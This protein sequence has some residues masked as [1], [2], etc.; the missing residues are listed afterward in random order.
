MRSVLDRVRH[1]VLFELIGVAIVSP[2]AGWLFH[3]PMHRVGALAVAI[4]LFAT[5]W[6][7]VYNLAF[8]HALRRIT[9]RV[10]KTSWER[11]LHAIV[12]EA[13]MLVFTLAP[14]MWWMGFGLG[15]AL[16]MN[17]ALMVFYLVYTYAYNL[18]YDII[19]PIPAQQPRG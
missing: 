17:V 14:V 9:G 10:Y 7:Y 13:G 4:S 6:N 3:A 11:I 19:F 18:A 1:A 8:D 5:V 16:T 2:L 12:F 15:E